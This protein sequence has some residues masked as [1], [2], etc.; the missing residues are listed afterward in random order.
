M[1][2]ICS[3]ILAFLMIFAAV[4]RAQDHYLFQARVR[5]ATIAVAA[6]GVGL[7]LTHGVT[8]GSLDEDGITTIQVPLRNGQTYTLVGTCDEDCSDLDLELVNPF[9]RVVSRDISDDDRPVVSATPLISG[10]YR[11]R[12]TMAE[13]SLGPCRFAVGIFGR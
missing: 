3:F 2:S 10:T 12:V 13:C 7:R 5:L 6:M 9:G 11:I 4:P 1:I 8:T